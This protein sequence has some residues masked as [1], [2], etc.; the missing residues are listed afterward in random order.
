M[1]VLYGFP[2]LGPDESCTEICLNNAVILSGR[3]EVSEEV[4]GLDKSSVQRG[5]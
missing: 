3:T 1:S 4:T 5:R 2:F